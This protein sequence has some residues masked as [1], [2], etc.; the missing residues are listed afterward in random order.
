[1]VH[2]QYVF[3]KLVAS[4]KVPELNGSK[5][6]F[7][8]GKIDENCISGEFSIATFD[9]WRVDWLDEFTTDPI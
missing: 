1:M 6:R 3:I 2:V 8:A 9:D 4:C 7:I 5:W